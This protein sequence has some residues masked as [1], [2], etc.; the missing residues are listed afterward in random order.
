VFIRGLSF[1]YLHLIT[2]ELFQRIAGGLF[3]GVFGAS[4]LPF[5]T[6]KVKPLTEIAYVFFSDRF[7]TTLTALMSDRWIVVDAIE[8]NAH[9]G[10]ALV[11]AFAAS[12][13]STDGIF[14]AA[15]VTMSR[16]F[17]H[18]SADDNPKMPVNQTCFQRFTF[19]RRARRFV[20][21]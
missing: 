3:A 18:G 8:A 6:L 4:A 16:Q 10:A 7:G 19:R 20:P 13:V 9:V 2:Q 12:G 14:P 11:T 15:F 17:R 21:K 1:P 5:A